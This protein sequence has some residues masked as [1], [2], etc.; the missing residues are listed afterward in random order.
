MLTV[1]AD[2][3]LHV[4]VLAGQFGQLVEVA[5]ET[6]LEQRQNHKM[7]RRHAGPTVAAVDALAKLLVRFVG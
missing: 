3:G 7:P 6:L 1:A 5:A 4:G 2:H